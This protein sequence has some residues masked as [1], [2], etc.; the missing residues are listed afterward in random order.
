MRSIKGLARLQR[1]RAW[2]LWQVS[3][4]ADE[5]ATVDAWLTEM[6]VRRY[7]IRDDKG[8]RVASWWQCWDGGLL[9]RPGGVRIIGQAIQHGFVCADRALWEAIAA[10]ER[11]PGFID[12]AVDPD[13]G[14]EVGLFRAPRVPDDV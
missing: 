8:A 2:V 10:A 6:K 5:Y 12:W 4:G 9:F 3:G 13:P 11:S 1:R 14:G 7:T